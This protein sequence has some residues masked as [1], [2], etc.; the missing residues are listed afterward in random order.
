MSDQSKILNA[1]TRNR[2]VYIANSLFA[3]ALSF[4]QPRT[5]LKIDFM[6]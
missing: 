2:F 6:R 4:L 3:T 5:D 1:L